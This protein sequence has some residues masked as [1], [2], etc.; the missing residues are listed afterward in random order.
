MSN[1][2]SL[3]PFFRRVQPTTWRR[4]KTQKPKLQILRTKTQNPLSSTRKASR[5]LWNNALL[6]A[7]G[8]WYL[9]RFTRAGRWLLGAT[10]VFGLS[11]ASSLELQFYPAFLYAASLWFLAALLSRRR[12]RVALQTRYATRISA[13][14]TLPV[15]IEIT[16]ARRN[17]ELCVVPFRLPREVEASPLHGLI[18][19]PLSA[20]ETWRG[21]LSL[22]C[23]RRGIYVIRGW[24]VESDFPFGLLRTRQ[25]FKSETALLVLPRFAPL[26]SLEL[27]SNQSAWNGVAQPSCVGDSFELLGNREW[28]DGDSRRDINWR[29]TA[30]LQK[31]VVREMCHERWPRANIILDTHIATTKTPFSLA[32]LFRSS[33]SSAPNDDFERAVSLCAAVTNF[34]ARENFVVE[35]F[36]AGAHL[37]HLD[38]EPNTS[39]RD[40]I[41]DCLASVQSAP[42]SHFQELSAALQS[43]GKIASTTICLLL[44]WDEARRDFIHQLQRDG[45]FVKT[46]IVRDGAPSLSLE[47]LNNCTV[48]NR[49]QFESGV[50]CL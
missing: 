45:A 15:E 20:G 40:A 28:R 34:M 50:N 32:Q 46:I 16:A 13:G 35:L 23:A 39:Q 12:P 11:G 42:Q 17:G 14:E 7:L 19:A 25:S 9:E 8:N 21:Q 18:V 36:A 47:N 38:A 26:Q 3:R 2:R 1:A 6:Q 33:T 24:S 31:T 44:D 10:L 22:K 41:L 27:P 5:A 43:T 4:V 48:I 49:A 37:L 29:A 30:R